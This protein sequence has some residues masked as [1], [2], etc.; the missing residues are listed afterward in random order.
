MLHEIYHRLVI[1]FFISNHIFFL[2][3]NWWILPSVFQNKEVASLICE[4]HP[5]SVVYEM[6]K[7]SLY[8]V[9]HLEV[10][11]VALITWSEFMAN[12]ANWHRDIYLQVAELCVFSINP[13]YSWLCISSCLNIYNIW[14]VKYTFRIANTSCILVDFLCPGK[15]F[16]LNSLL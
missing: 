12:V 5:Y 8:G 1:N 2:I 15:M 4:I 10:L 9:C 14:Q 3:F 16:H 7:T 11:S 6:Y 13:N